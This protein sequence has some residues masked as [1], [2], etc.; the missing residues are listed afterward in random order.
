MLILCY[1]G[2]ET[3]KYK[4]YYKILIFIFYYVQTN[5]SVFLNHPFFTIALSYDLIYFIN[6]CYNLGKLLFY[7]VTMFLPV[8]KKDNCPNELPGSIIT[9]QSYSSGSALFKLNFKIPDSIPCDTIWISS[10]HIFSMWSGEKIDTMDKNMYVFYKWRVMERSNACSSFCSVGLGWV[11]FFSLVTLAFKCTF[12]SCFL[13]DLIEKKIKL[14]AKN[15]GEKNILNIGT[16]TRQVVVKKIQKQEFVCFVFY[17]VILPGYFLP[18]LVNQRNT[19]R[20][21]ETNCYK[22]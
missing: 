15:K 7:K 14:N 12:V 9:T 8:T 11:F 10:P 2:Y 19:I 13:L 18:F 17:L 16:S 4:Q 5:G 6:L 21:T 3:V 1:R 22:L 20:E